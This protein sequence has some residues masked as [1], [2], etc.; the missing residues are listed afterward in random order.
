MW[1]TFTRFVMAKAAPRAFFA[2]DSTGPSLVNE[3][4]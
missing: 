4:V 1:N 3:E 2:A